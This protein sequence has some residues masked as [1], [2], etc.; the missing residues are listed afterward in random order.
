MS[1]QNVYFIR[2]V[3][4]GDFQIYHLINIETFS[5][6]DIFFETEDEAI[7]YAKKNNL[8]ITTYSEK[9]VENANGK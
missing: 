7:L 4:K 1:N 6:L 3:G 2:K 8:M 5:M 9:L